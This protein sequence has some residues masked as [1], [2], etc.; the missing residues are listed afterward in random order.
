[1]AV[2]FREHH[3]GNRRIVPA[4]LRMRQKSHGALGLRPHQRLPDCK[5]A[6]NVVWS[7]LDR[8]DLSEVLLVL[9]P[10]TTPNV[11]N[12]QEGRN[13]DVIGIVLESFLKLRRSRLGR[14]RRD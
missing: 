3:A 11:G 8:F 12:C 9:L 10:A 13:G 6:H 2:C 4:I 14:C 7:E 1:M 5:M